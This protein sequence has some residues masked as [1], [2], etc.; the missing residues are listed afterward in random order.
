MRESFFKPRL[1]AIVIIGL[2]QLVVSG[3]VEEGWF[4]PKSCKEAAAYKKTG[5]WDR[6]IYKSVE[7]LMARLSD[8]WID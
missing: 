1:A 4:D 7:C 2:M 6:A 3:C 8:R 5:D